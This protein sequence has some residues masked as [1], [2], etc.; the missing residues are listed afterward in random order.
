[1]DNIKLAAIMYIAAG[2]LFAVTG[3]LGGNILILPVGAVLVVLGMRKLKQHQQ[4]QNNDP[5]E[6]W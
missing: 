5:D 2:V 6:A 3:I 1:M 4:D